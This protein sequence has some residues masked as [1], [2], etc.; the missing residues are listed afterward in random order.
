MIPPA[1]QY[2]EQ[3]PHDDHPRTEQVKREVHG[4]HRCGCRWNER[5]KSKTDVS[6]APHI[7]YFLFIT[8]DKTRGT[9]KTYMSVGVTKT[10]CL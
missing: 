9:Q 4:I 3:I 7:H 10:I 1:V 2:L 5:L 6:K 8:N